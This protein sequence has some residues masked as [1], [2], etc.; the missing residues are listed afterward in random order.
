MV[1]R[2]RNHVVVILVGALCHSAN[3]R[4]SVA[5]CAAIFR[6][7]RPSP[8]IGS[9]SGCARDPFGPGLFRP[10]PPFPLCGWLSALRI[11]GG[12]YLIVPHLVLFPIQTTHRPTCTYTYGHV[13]NGHSHSHCPITITAIEHCSRGH[14]QRPTRCA[15]ATYSRQRQRNLT[16]AREHR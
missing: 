16:S 4:L 5:A 10:L 11:R 8:L 7:L 3:H 13:L 1:K 14:K 15:T 12:I 2:P 9:G 6:P